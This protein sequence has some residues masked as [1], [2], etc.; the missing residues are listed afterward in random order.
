MDFM[1]P[2]TLY[3]SNIC[4]LQ[5]DAFFNPSFQW[6]IIQH[7]TYNWRI[8]FCICKLNNSEA[9]MELWGPV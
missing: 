5:Y 7:L 2:Q 9:P 3:E 8:A 4:K 1:V 6:A